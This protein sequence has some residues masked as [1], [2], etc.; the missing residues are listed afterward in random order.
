MI[1]SLMYLIAYRP[2][3]IDYPSELVAYINSDYAGASLDKKFTIEGYQ[4]LGTR[5]IIWQCKKQIV[6]ATSTTKAEYVPAASCCGQTS[7]PIPNVADEAV[8]E[9]WDE[10][11]E[12]AV[13][14]AASLDPEQ[15]SGNINRTQSTTM[16][17]VPLPQRSGAGGSPMCQEAIRGSTSQTRSKRVPTP[18][19]DSPF[20][21]VHPPGSDEERFEQNEL[22]GNVQQQ[23][24]DLPL[25]KGHTLG[26]GEDSIE[27][28]KEFMETC[29]KLS[30]RVLT[31][32]ESKTAQDLV[33][34]RDYPSELVA[35][36][37]SDYAGAS[38]DKK[39]TI[40][41]YQFLGTRLI[42]W[43]CKK[44]IVVATSTTKAEYVPAASCCGQTSEPIPNVAD[45]A[46]YEEWDE[47]VERAVTTAASLDPEQASG[48][49][50]RTQ[51]TTMPNVPLPQRSGA[52]GSPMC[53]EAIR[54]STSQTRS[55]R[56]PTPSYDSPFLGVH[57]PGSDEERFE[58]NELTGNVQQQSN[59][60]P[61]S[62]GHTLGS[63]EDSI[64]VI[65]EFMETCTKLSKRVLTL[66]ESKTAQDLVITRLKLSVNKLEKN[67]KRAR[68]PQ[69][70]KRRLF[71]VRVESF[72]KENLYEEDLSKLGR[73]FYKV[74]LKNGQTYTR[75]RRVVSTSS[76]EI[77]TASRVNVSIPSPVT[78]KDKGKDKMEESKDEQTKRTKLQQEQDRL[79]YEAAVRLQEELD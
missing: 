30:K 58:Q 23:S 67:K 7:E 50:N 33:I 51:S 25:S 40:E 66:E 70:L 49:I 79:G 11:V 1:R 21:G 45:E 72:A 48:N 43:Q 64:E 20:L 16:P 63:G 32:E 24:N 44:Q 59:D 53:Q 9:E 47:R 65:K 2:D 35:Y 13:T 36:I 5:L 8:Y 68:T 27:V 15:A 38:L 71:K 75:R 14:T 62:K 10:R 29:T 19:Y 56:V 28:I 12:R 52:G 31:L 69:P 22:T 37:N 74:Q 54:G 4:F 61:L 78:V 34:T 55:K 42:I 3:I 39:F 76:G 26:S 41:G 6:V 77:S 57:P 18:S 60:L 46:V 73:S 17:N